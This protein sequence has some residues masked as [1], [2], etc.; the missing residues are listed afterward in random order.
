[1]ENWGLVTCREVALL[2]D[3]ANSSASSRQWVALVVGHELAHMWFGNLVTMVIA[4]TFH[5]TYMYA[6]TMHPR[7]LTMKID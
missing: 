5:E 3:P 1:M 4:A 2:I 7:I 6:I